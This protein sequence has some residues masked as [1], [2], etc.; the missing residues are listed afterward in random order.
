M[1]TAIRINEAKEMEMATAALRLWPPLSLGEGTNPEIAF[2]KWNGVGCM[3]KVG[4]MCRV[5][6]Y[7]HACRHA[8]EWTDGNLLYV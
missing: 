4:G 5:L 6:S 2:C 3:E 1:G 7:V 8:N